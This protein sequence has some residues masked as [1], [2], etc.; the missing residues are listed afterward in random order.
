MKTPTVLEGYL[1]GLKF[2]LGQMQAMRYSLVERLGEEPTMCP[3]SYG[4]IE[5]LQ[6]GISH[7]HLGTSTI[8]AEIK[9][10][11]RELESWSLWHWTR[12]MSDECN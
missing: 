12:G 8:E 7:F 9:T 10:A 5:G 6:E 1:E 4:I 2:G 3:H 11:E